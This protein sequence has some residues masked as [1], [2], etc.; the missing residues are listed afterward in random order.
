M[1]D[2]VNYPG[3]DGGV[4]VA[5]QYVSFSAGSLARESTECVL[6]GSN[7][8]L[9][10]TALLGIDRPLPHLH[11]PPVS[12]GEPPS[13]GPISATNMAGLCVRTPLI[14]RRDRPPP[15]DIRND[16]H[17]IFDITSRRSKA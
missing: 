15:P 6:M 3:K 11:P 9:W 16:C 5:S 2:G 13:N 17:D 8:N 7:S 10:D 12:F 14:T 1:V 4:G